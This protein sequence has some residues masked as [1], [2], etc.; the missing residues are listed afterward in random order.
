MGDYDKIDKIS[1]NY[2][3]MHHS[4]TVG[5]NAQTFNCMYGSSLVDTANSYSYMVSMRPPVNTAVSRVN[6]SE[7]AVSSSDL[8]GNL[9]GVF[10]NPS[11][12]W[13]RPRQAGI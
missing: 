4:V 7:C 11:S 2:D 13:I 1:V 5:S 6:G 3:K 8:T 12:G 9:H 10:P